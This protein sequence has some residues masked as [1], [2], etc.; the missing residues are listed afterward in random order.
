VSKFDGLDDQIAQHDLESLKNGGPDQLPATLSAAVDSRAKALDRFSRMAVLRDRCAE[1]CDKAATA[2]PTLR[3]ELQ[4]AVNAVSVGEAR[5]LLELYK[6]ALGQ[7]G[8][9]QLSGRPVS[10][11]PLRHVPR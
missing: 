10:A 2:L 1:Q 6:S 8:A 11:A 5:R 9:K 3:A 7:L 4:F